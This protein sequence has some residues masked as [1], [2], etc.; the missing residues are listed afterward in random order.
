MPGGTKPEIT[1]ES[2]IDSNG[3]SSETIILTG[4][5]PRAVPVER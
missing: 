5:W 3:M 1:V 2:G 4:R